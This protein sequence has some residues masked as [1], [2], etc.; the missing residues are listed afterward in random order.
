MAGLHALA[1][2][3]QGYGDT[4]EA[5]VDLVAANQGRDG[6]WPLADT[7]STLEALLATGL[8][9][10]RKAVRRTAPALADRQRADGSLGPTAQQERALVGLRAMLWAEAAR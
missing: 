7:F 5:L 6:H 4:V 1:L 3:G 10:A 8:P 2:G 9:A